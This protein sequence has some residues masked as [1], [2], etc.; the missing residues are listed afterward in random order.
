MPSL[1]A[2]R[3]WWAPG[4]ALLCA[5]CAAKAPPAPVAPPVATY[6]QKVAAILRLEDRRILEDP[7]APPPAVTSLLPLLNDDEG[8]VRRRAALAVGRTGLTAAVAPLQGVLANDGEPEVRA[9]AAFALGLIGDGAAVTP[10]L[11]ALADADARVQGRAAE[12]LGLIGAKAAAGPVA[13]MVATHVRAG[14]LSGIDADELRY[15]LAP[16]VEAIRLGVYALVRLGDIAALRTAVLTADGTPASDWWPLAYAM[17]RIGHADALPVLRGWLTRGGALTRA[18]AVKGL[19]GLKDAAARAP[20]ESLAA[21]ARQP[22]EH[23]RA[24]DSRARGHRRSALG[25]DADRA[26]AAVHGRRP[27]VSKRRRR[28][29]RWPDRRWPSRSSTTSKT[30]GRRCAR[31]RRRPWPRATSMPS[32]R[33]CRGCS[34]TRSGAC[35]PHWRRRSAD[36]RPRRP[37]RG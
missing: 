4:A 3:R 31:R 22:I 19:A 12:A 36:S 11:A 27:C 6:E 29:P 5:A 14:A 32:C 16:P 28:L 23:P 35:A 9:M 1:L 37:V 18:F 7:P 21:D 33:C 10:L 15:P 34:A 2:S 30:T 25:G 24:G 26:A 13:Q 17:Q 8:R 20:L